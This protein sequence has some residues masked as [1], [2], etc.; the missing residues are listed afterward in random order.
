MPCRRRRNWAAAR[1]RAPS[2][3]EV[4]MT[5][6]VRRNTLPVR[7]PRTGEVDYHIAP[8]TAAEVAAK[9]RDL[10]AAQKDWAAA[11]I[12]HRCDVMRRWADAIEKNRKAI[13]AAE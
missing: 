4:P 9:A 12:E 7:N 8:P 2:A 3:I 1:R 5:D 11:P 13:S 6:A 10:R